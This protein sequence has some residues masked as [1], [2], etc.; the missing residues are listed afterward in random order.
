MKKALFLLPF[1][2][3]FSF[4]VQCGSK[5]EKNI[6]L[7]PE[8]P[9]VYDQRLPK[10]YNPD[11]SYPLLIILHG[12]LSDEKK[13]P[14]VWDEGFFYEPNFILL[15]VRAPFKKKRGGFTWITESESLRCN[16]GL[17]RK[18]SARVSEERVLD[19]YH[20]FQEKYKIDINSVFLCGFSQGA[21]PALFV[22][23]RHPE[24]FAG[25]ALMS[26]KMDISLFSDME[27]KG[28][29]GKK[30]FLVGE[31]ENPKLNNALREIR[32]RLSAL[33][34]DVRFYAF[35][36]GHILTGRKCRMMQNF[37]GLCEERA[38]EDDLIYEETGD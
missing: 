14:M 29:A 22:G 10:N 37:F 36:G 6:K 17:R 31:E 30:F 3:F 5:K 18:L 26:G 27:L 12:Y 13:G 23:L 35:P 16:L 25:V 7:A 34:A 32:D 2:F 15:S 4:L 28:L 21:E 11:K 8:V 19:V 24:I 20:I 1:I 9:I 33:G 38:P